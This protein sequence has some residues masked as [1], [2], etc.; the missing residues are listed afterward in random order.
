MRVAFTSDIHVDISR[1]NHLLVDLMVEHLQVETPDVFILCGDISPSSEQ[2]A[3]TLARFRPVSC[4]KLMVP[5]NHDVWVDSKN[6]LKKGIDSTI[7]YTQILPQACQENDFLCFGTEPFQ[8]DKI[9]FAGCMGW[10]DYSYRNPLFDDTIHEDAYKAGELILGSDRPEVSFWNDKRYAW[11]LRRPGQHLFNLRSRAV[12]RP[13]K[14]I[15]GEMILSLGNQLKTL[16]STGVDRIVVVTH[17]VSFRD[18][19]IY[20]DELP[21]DF[22]TAYDGS[23]ELERTIRSCRLVTHCLCGHS[24]TLKDRM[25]GSIR[26]MS[27]PVG[28][29]TKMGAE[30]LR[31]VAVEKL[32]F[33]DV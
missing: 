11:W 23:E 6:K 8:L 31:Q 16:E 15:C 13:D 17:F 14:D 33:V 29:L 20:K 2:F 1:E 10:Y 22:F 28:Y 4:K 27:S 19:V 7:K 21:I 30:Q 9:G 32:M 12:C 24:H 18:M 25:I 5:G 3:E 26:A